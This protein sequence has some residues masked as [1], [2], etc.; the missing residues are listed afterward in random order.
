MADNLITSAVVNGT[1]ASAIIGATDAAGVF[2]LN[3]T[4]D[5]ADASLIIPGVVQASAQNLA[6]PLAAKSLGDGVYALCVASA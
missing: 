3:V 6:A 1:G 4:T 5:A 2:T